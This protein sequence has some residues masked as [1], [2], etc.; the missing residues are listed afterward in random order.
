MKL[1]MDCMRAILFEV[2]K[3]EYNE[4]LLIFE[5]ERTIS[6][7]PPDVIRYSCLKLKESG[8]IN[9]VTICDE[10]SALPL[11]A[12]I[13]DITY[14]G[15]QF[16]AKVR[17]SSRWSIIR[18]GLSEKVHDYSLSA[19]TAIADGMTSAAISA[20]FAGQLNL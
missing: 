10:E 13:L 1:D 4:T 8:L 20:F 9:A 12:E 14:P 18:K 7:Y 11:V 2:E 3:L 17:D 16:L 19:I 5:L 15:H 6:K